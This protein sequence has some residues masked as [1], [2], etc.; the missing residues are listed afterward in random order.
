MKLIEYYKKEVGSNITV[1]RIRV[2][3]PRESG[4]VEGREREKRGK[5]YYRPRENKQS[6][7]AVFAKYQILYSILLECRVSI[8]YSSSLLYSMERRVKVGGRRERER[9][10]RRGDVMSGI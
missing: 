5:Q 9:S 1:G 8:L 4:R 10:Q 7:R 2:S 6:L 3:L